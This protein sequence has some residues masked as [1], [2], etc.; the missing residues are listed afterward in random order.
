MKL[1]CEKQAREKYV[2]KV[3][4]AKTTKNIFNGFYRN[5][6]ARKKSGSIWIESSADAK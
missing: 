1:L 4:T 2:Y 5:L 6:K 3:W